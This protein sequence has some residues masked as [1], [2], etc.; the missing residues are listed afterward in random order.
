MAR[1]QYTITNILISSLTEVCNVHLQKTKDAK[2]VI[3][4]KC[5][6]E[7]NIFQKNKKCK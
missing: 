6:I 4:V 5:N 1:T 7:Y 2:N 3:L